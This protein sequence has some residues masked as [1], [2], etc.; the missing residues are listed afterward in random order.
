MAKHLCF[1]I[2]GDVTNIFEYIRQ[3]QDARGVD[4]FSEIQ[5]CVVAVRQLAYGSVS[6]SWDKYFQMLKCV[7]RDSLDEFCICVV[8]IYG[9]WYLRKLTFTNVQS[10][11]V[12]HVSVHGFPSMLEGLDCLHWAWGSCPNAW[13]WQFTRGDKGHPTVILEVIVSHDLWIWH[14]FFGA[15]NS[16]NDINV[17][18]MSSIFNGFC[19]AS[20]PNYPFQVNGT[21]YSYGYYLVDDIY[22]EFVVFVKTLTCLGDPKRIKYKTYQEKAK[23]DV[24]R[25][26]GVLKK[27]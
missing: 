26:F 4:G 5:K 21:T 24:E 25:A 15:P 17:L 6:D 12:H 14:V 9:P 8:T 1:R 23:N 19:D 22:P 16:N 2:V 10:L 3:R 11:Y 27:R 18:D 13:Q 20:A 7:A